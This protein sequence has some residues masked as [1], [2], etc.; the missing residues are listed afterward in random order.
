MGF[1]GNL[2]DKIGRV[3][4]AT[5][6]QKRPPRGPLNLAV[7]DF[8]THYRER[9]E[10]TGVR[11]VAGDGPPAIHYCLRDQRGVR[12]VLSAEDRPDPA[13]AL[14]R[15]VNGEVPWDA[16]VLTGISDEPFRAVRRGRA[17]VRA[18]GDAGLPEGSRSMEYREF[19]DAAGDRVLVIEDHQGIREARIGEPV[20]ETELDFE[21]AEGGGSGGGTFSTA[22]GVK[23]FEDQAREDVVK[24]TPRAA[25]L[26]LDRNV[27]TAGPG[28][29]EADVD[30]DP[31][32]DDESWGDA[33]GK[34]PD[35]ARLRT[36]AAARPHQH[37]HD[38]EWLSAAQ[39]IRRNRG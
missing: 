6:P 19:E 37:E 38:D 26:A 13:C 29:Q 21:R 4:P 5:T 7:G 36:K 11:Q 14:Q 31:T 20:F 32:A 2:L 12:A 24:G 15:N 35:E 34:E 22:L 28:Q 39:R 33:L 3:A 23:T 30:H 25:A 1:L 17:N 8:V 27:G 18:W 16:D 9:F 10:V